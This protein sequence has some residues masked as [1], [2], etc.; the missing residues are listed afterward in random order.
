MN[1]SIV[2]SAFLWAM[3]G[4]YIWILIRFR[5]FDAAY[6]FDPAQAKVFEARVYSGAITTAVLLYFVF[7]GVEEQ[8]WAKNWKV[9]L[10]L[11]AFVL[12]YAGRLQVALLTAMVER[13]EDGINTVF[14]ARQQKSKTPP[15]DALK[16]P[17]SKTDKPK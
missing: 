6:T 16:K 4:S 2:I 7:G 8:A 12:G 11:W 13:V 1:F 14:P 5:K 9:D 3:T 15:D 17:P 10:P